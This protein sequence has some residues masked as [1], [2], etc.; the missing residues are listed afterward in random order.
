MPLGQ[1]VLLGLLLLE[2]SKK[3]LKALHRDECAT[4]FSNRIRNLLLRF[5]CILSD[6][7]GAV[8]LLQALLRQIRHRH[9]IRTQELTFTLMQTLPPFGINHCEIIDIEGTVKVGI[10]I[11]AVTTAHA[12]IQE[13]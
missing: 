4:G 7:G 5:D 1:V 11:T 2:L 12:C 13:G 8:P 9:E 6:E 3:R 10:N